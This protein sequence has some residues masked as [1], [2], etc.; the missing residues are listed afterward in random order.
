MIFE[1][2]PGD[3]EALANNQAATV[4]SKEGRP[5]LPV[6]LSRLSCLSVSLRSWLGNRTGQCLHALSQAVCLATKDRMRRICRLPIYPR[7]DKI[8]GKFQIVQLPIPGSLGSL[9]FAAQSQSNLRRLN[10]PQQSGDITS[11]SFGGQLCGS[12]RSRAIP[13]PDDQPAIVGRST[14]LVDFSFLHRMNVDV[15]KAVRICREWFCPVDMPVPEQDSHHS[16]PI[17]SEFSPREFVGVDEVESRRRP[18]EGP[19]SISTR[20]NVAVPDTYTP[21]LEWKS[22]DLIII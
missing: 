9:P 4:R 17:L 21:S 14:R 16:N 7:Q 22:R 13:V 5:G 10:S 19:S 8:T 18:Q 11:T 1:T 15:G 3:S 6:S 12:C 2:R 20:S